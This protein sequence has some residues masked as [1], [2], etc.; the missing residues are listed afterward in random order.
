MDKNSM[1]KKFTFSYILG[2]AFCIAALIFNY[3]N[4]EFHIM[5]ILIVC[6]GTS[7]NIMAVLHSVTFSKPKAKLEENNES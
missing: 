3:N 2:I 6:I 7:I 5:N 1:D 4:G